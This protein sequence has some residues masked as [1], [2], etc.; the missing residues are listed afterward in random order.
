MSTATLNPQQAQKLQE[1]G[2]KLRQTRESKSIALQ[3]ITASTLIAERHLRAIEEGN[4]ASLP[5]PIYIRGFI[6]KY[7]TAVGMADIAEEFPLVS[8]LTEERTVRAPILEFRPYH[9]YAVYVA[10]I[11]GSI[12]ALSLVFNNQEKKLEVI[13]VP[14][15]PAVE[16]TSP[17]TPVALQQRPKVAEP[18]TVEVKPSAPEGNQANATIGLIRWLN[19]SL[20]LN[21]Q[22]ETNG[23]I[24]PNS[25]ITSTTATSITATSTTSQVPTDVGTPVRVS[26]MPN[27]ST[28]ISVDVDG[29]LAFEGLLTPEV[30]ATTLRW[31]AQ[32]EVT[33]RASDGSK[34]LMILN[35]QPPILLSNR[36]QEANVLVTSEFQPP[37]VGI[38]GVLRDV[39]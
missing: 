9:L 11:A 26:L 39:Y 21:N 20:L 33:I 18:R 2:E 16:R 24:P 4:F 14:A 29:K 27:G 15:P 10:V 12:T 25:T 36:G 7:G 1:I 28:W 19:D 35:D 31:I 5:E 3:Q 34:A 8:A 23:L 38:E 22:W 13:P 32:R 6:R 37:E 30:D 17:I